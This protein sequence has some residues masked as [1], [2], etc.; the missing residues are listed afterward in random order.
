MPA[1]IELLLRGRIDVQK[2]DG[3]RGVRSLGL[4][5]LQSPRNC[6]AIAVPDHSPDYKERKKPEPHSK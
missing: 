2:I 6:C 4:R 3:C 1:G 5:S